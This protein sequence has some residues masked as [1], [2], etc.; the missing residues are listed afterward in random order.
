MSA[1]SWCERLPLE[2]VL[3]TASPVQPIRSVDSVDAKQ[4]FIV[5]MR[6]HERP[7]AP[8]LNPSAHTAIMSDCNV[9]YRTPGG[10]CFAMSFPSHELAR[11]WFTSTERF[12]R[13]VRTIYTTA[14]WN[15]DDADVMSLWIVEWIQCTCRPTRRYP[16]P[17]VLLWEI[18]SNRIESNRIE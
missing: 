8:I 2:L 4:R 10:K 15:S 11:E 1:S 16:V 7:P 13:E 18:E 6:M 5:L 3:P 14:F 12:N 17:A 9:L